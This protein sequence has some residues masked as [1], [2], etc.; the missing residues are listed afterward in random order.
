[1]NTYVV[2]IISLKSIQMFESISISDDSIVNTFQVLHYCWKDILTIY[3]IINCKIG[4]I[5]WIVLYDTHKTKK[6]MSS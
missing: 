3:Y 6:L 1:M 2:I 4:C 5:D